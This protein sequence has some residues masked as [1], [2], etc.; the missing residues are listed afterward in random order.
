L[1]VSTKENQVFG[2]KN[3]VFASFDKG[4][5]DGFVIISIAYRV[6][7]GRASLAVIAGLDPAIQAVRMQ[8]SSKAL[9]DL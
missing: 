5:V 2:E 1:Q 9:H 4:P 3:Q 8:R 7:A 6:S